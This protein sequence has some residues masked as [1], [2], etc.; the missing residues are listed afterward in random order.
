V[1]L[2]TSGSGDWLCELAWWPVEKMTLD[3]LL[4]SVSEHPM[5]AAAA[6]ARDAGYDFVRDFRAARAAISSVARPKRA[7]AGLEADD[8]LAGVRVMDHQRVDFV[9]RDVLLPQRL[10]R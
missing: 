3:A 8:A 9:L 2:S 5:A 6:K 10:R 7:V 4:R 1:A